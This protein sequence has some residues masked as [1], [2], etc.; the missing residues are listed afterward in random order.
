MELIIATRNV[1]KVTEVKSILS[2]LG[3]TILS[4][5]DITERISIMETGLTFVEN[6]KLKALKVAVHVDGIIL[7]D[8]SGLEVDELGGEPGV[9]SAR[10]AGPE[11]TD[12]ENNR[13]LL[14]AMEGVP[15]ERRQARF[16]CVIAL[17]D[18]K[19]RLYISEGVCE[20][21]IAFEPSGQCGFGY[22]PIFYLPQYGSTMAQLPPEIKNSISHRARALEKAKGILKIQT[23]R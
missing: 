17:V 20:G 15:W 3:M 1:H 5:H 11:A 19:K 16:R 22:D 8:D 4:L 18:F 12:I 2:D 13:K 6:A 9:F 23:C 14:A 21:I 10:Y 7:A